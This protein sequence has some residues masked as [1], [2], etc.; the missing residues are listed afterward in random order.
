MTLGA[1]LVGRL[2]QLATTEAFCASTV[3][4]QMR[5]HRALRVVMDG[6]VLFLRPPLDVTLRPGALQVLAPAMEHG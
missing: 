4:V 3:R 1:G 2:E 6:E 5:R